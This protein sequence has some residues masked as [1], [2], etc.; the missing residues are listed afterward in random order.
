[1]KGLAENCY[2]WMQVYLVARSSK[3]GFVRVAT[4]ASKLSEAQLKRY[5]KLINI[6]LASDTFLNYVLFRFSCLFES[7]MVLRIDN[8]LESVTYNG[9][10]VSEV[11]NQ[12]ISTLAMVGHVVYAP[13]GMSLHTIYNPNEINNI[14]EFD[15][16]NIDNL[17]PF[18]DIL[19]YLISDDVNY[20]VFKIISRLYNWV[21]CIEEFCF[22]VEYA[23]LHRN[24]LL[25]N[26]ITLTDLGRYF[27]KVHMMVRD[28]L[29]VIKVQF[30]NYKMFEAHPDMQRLS[31]KI[32]RLG[33]L[34]DKIFSEIKEKGINAEA[35]NFY[36]GY[37]QY[38]SNFI[39]EEAIIKGLQNTIMNLL[40]IN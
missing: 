40:Y 1:M 2:K 26:N 11:V 25:E 24:K 30:K 13:D 27:E 39:D 37:A 12:T 3:E 29:E 7:I 31:I 32:E 23:L 9:L 10:T 14:R 33:V 15:L 8:K 19:N 20:K 34:V 18:T 28:L 35:L 5:E 4:D 22:D 38:F 21:I 36:Q 16:Y 17:R 6:D